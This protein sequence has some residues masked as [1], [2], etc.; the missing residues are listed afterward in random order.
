MVG[1]HGNGTGLST[2]D[3]YRDAITA[4]GARRRPTGVF[5]AGPQQ[6]ATGV[7]TEF[8]CDGHEHHL[9]RESA[10]QNIGVTRR[11]HG[12]PD[13]KNASDVENATE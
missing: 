2:R 9:E 3:G 7:A 12:L 5:F 8:D 11:K 10:R 6:L 4:R 1:D 13:E